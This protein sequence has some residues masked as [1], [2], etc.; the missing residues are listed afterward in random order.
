MR[1]SLCSGR[2]PHRNGQQRTDVVVAEDRRL[3]RRGLWA[4]VEAEFLVEEGAEAAVAVERLILASERVEGEHGG[5]V[6]AIA[7]AI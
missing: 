6:G 4:G 7:E 2:A 5:A 3:E 1:S